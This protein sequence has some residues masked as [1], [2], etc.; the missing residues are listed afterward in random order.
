M[1]T[2]SWLEILLAVI[3][4]VGS[5]AGYLGFRMGHEVAERK[6]LVRLRDAAIK[7]CIANH[8]AGKRMG[9]QPALTVVDPS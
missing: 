7:A 5:A 3:V 1:N 4:I 9:E 2:L 8:P 6:E